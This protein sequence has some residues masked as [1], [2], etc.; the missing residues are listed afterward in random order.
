MLV[1]KPLPEPVDLRPPPGHGSELEGVADEGQGSR[2]R[3]GGPGLERACF[4]VFVEFFFLGERESER[5]SEQV[6][7]VAPFFFWQARATSFLVENLPLLNQ[8]NKLGIFIWFFE[9]L[10]RIGESRK[11]VFRA[12]EESHACHMLDSTRLAAIIS[13]SSFAHLSSSSRAATR[14]GAARSNPG[15]S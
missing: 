8:A 4:G 3:E 11:R 13:I 5:A 10:V 1:R 14:T 12:W 2:A 7:A 9:T 15:R 6:R